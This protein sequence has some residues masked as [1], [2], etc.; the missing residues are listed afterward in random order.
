MSIRIADGTQIFKCR[1]YFFYL[2]LSFLSGILLT[3]SALHAIRRRSDS[4]NDYRT[5][6]GSPILQA[7]LK[8]FCCVSVFYKFLQY[9]APQLMSDLLFFYP[10]FHLPTQIQTN[11]ILI[12][13]HNVTVFTTA[14]KTTSNFNT[15]TTFEEN[16]SLC[17]VI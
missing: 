11:N 10:F 3:F 8:G 6:H 15:E 5:V 14:Q 2:N 16:I 13:R 7:N 4:R 1:F 9:H 17:E 12:G